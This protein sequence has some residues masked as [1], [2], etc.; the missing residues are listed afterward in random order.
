MTCN[1]CLL[2][3]L[4]FFKTSDLNASFTTEIHDYPPATT[5]HLKKLNENKNNTSISSSK[6]TGINVS[7]QRIFTYVRHGLKT[8]NINITM[9]RQMVIMQFL[10]IEPIREVVE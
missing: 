3:T 1:E 9:S 4:K 5:P 10:K 7:L 2:S 8:I 6:C